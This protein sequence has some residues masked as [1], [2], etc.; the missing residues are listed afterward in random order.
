MITY[1]KETH[2]ETRL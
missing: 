2:S 1:D